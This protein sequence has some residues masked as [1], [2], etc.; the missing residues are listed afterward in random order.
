MYCIFYF[1]DRF[2]KIF[3]CQLTKLIALDRLYEFRLLLTNTLLT[4]L[5]L[6]ILNLS[7]TSG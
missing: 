7:G 6:K 4:L 1:I 3:F 5:G 2:R